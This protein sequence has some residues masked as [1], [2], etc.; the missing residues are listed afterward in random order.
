[1]Y[2]SAP[3]PFSRAALLGWSAI[4]FIPALLLYDLIH[5]SMAAIYFPF[6]PLAA[7]ATWLVTLPFGMMTS[8]FREWVAGGPLS[9]VFAVLLC[10]SMLSR[11]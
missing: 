7:V 3:R 9:V 10:A 1:M 8:R 6:I 2:L 4:N 11:F 5:N